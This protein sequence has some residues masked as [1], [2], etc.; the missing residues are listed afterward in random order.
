MP[1]CLLRALIYFSIIAL[2]LGCTLT[3][4]L[5]RHHDK[6]KVMVGDLTEA[7]YRDITAVLKA[8]SKTGLKDTLIIRYY[9][10]NDACWA[11]LDQHGDEHINSVI[12][13]KQLQVQ[14]EQNRRLNLSVF[15]FREASDRMSKVILRDSTII[16]DPQH[17]LFNLALSDRSSC[18]NSIII[19]PDR[20][21]VLIR[22]DGHFEALN[23]SKEMIAN[24]LVSK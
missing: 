3:A 23:Y 9:Y 22:S 12:S 11:L 14:H 19:L 17:R 16:L 8:Y 15:Q 2:L 20:K 1:H 6:G 24:I 5:F 7:G 18:G 10:I 4:P 21:F 13:N